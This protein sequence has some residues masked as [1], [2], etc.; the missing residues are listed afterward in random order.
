MEIRKINTIA[1]ML[2]G[3]LCGAAITHAQQDSGYWRASSSN[4]AAITGD[5]R[6][7]GSRLTINYAMFPLAQIRTV[8]PSE[9]SAVFDADSNSPIGG[10][11]YR[12]RVPAEEKFLRHNTLC[13]HDD[14]Q[15][16]VTYTSGRSLQ[17]AFF[18]GAEMPVLT[19]DALA[20]STDLCGTFT[21][22]R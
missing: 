14:T 4:A 8:T 9:V 2:A 17:V 12:L 20:H 16:M 15:W 11:L 1:F 6:I 3:I 21:Y 18:S 13:G 22:V 10:N 5:V 19:I 7:A